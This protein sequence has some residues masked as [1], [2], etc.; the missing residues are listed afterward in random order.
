MCPQLVWKEK[1]SR[2]TLS[3]KEMRLKGSQG[4]FL[5]QGERLCVNSS[6]SETMA[7]WKIREARD[8]QM[9][10]KKCAQEQEAANRCGWPEGK[11]VQREVS[12]M[13]AKG[14]YDKILKLKVPSKI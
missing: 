7:R 3:E 5:W 8:F 13:F 10:W 2:R 6:H 1:N 12:K 14:K 11:M 4:P 9:A